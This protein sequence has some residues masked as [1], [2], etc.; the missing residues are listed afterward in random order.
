MI[1]KEALL[2]IFEKELATTLKAM[3]AFPEDRL[4]F[5][6]HERS[7][8][9]S[10]LMATFVFEMYLIE[11]CVFGEKIDRSKF[12]TYSPASLQTLT[13]DFENESSRV[14]SSIKT[15][16]DGDMRKAVE[17]AGKNMT[18]DRFML[19]MVFDMIHH[20]GQLSIYIRLAGGKVPSIYGPSADDPSRNL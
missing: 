1:P 3:R 10:Q 13:A 11:S 7:R 5:S 15:L 9:A 18:A 4:L 16:S 17:F 2:Q 14:V 12:Q 6:P 19:M 20:R 8:N